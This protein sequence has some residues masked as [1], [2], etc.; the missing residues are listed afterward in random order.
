MNWKKSTCSGQGANCVEVASLRD[1]IAVRDSKNP[2][3]PVL[4]FSADAW[5]AFVSN[6]KA[7]Q[8]G[9]SED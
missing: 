1:G 4:R 2:S 5:Q 3:G 8:L 7:G 6:I 9:A